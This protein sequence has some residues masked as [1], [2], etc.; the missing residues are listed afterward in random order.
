MKFYSF[1]AV[2]FRHN[3]IKK[4]ADALSKNSASVA[5]LYKFKEIKVENPT[6]FFVLIRFFY[7]ILV[8]SLSVPLYA[9][10]SSAKDFC[11]KSVRPEVLFSLRIRQ[12]YNSNSIFHH[13]APSHPNS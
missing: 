7:F 9:S 8:S 12:S 10:R 11:S 2:A 4:T 3:Q 6:V 1:G 5:S 13:F